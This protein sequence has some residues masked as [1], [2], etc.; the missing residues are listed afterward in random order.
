MKKK[1]IDSPAKGVGH[2][3]LMRM[4]EKFYVNL[5]SGIDVM[6]EDGSI[7][8]RTTVGTLL[9]IVEERIKK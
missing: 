5:K 7:T 6:L 3:L 9:K 8:K 1:E 2:K 4:V